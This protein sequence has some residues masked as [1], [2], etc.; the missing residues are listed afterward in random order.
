MRVISACSDKDMCSL[1]LPLTTAGEILT[2][3][4]NIPSP[5]PDN[6]Q[7]LSQPTW[8]RNN[9]LP[10]PDCLFFL[11]YKNVVYAT[12]VFTSF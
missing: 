1:L 2:P 7:F 4:F 8:A 6:P 3:A 5:H 12:L 9:Y 10:P 11:S